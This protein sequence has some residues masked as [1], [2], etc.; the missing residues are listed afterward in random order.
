MLIRFHIQLS[1]YFH[2]QV[3][4]IQDPVERKYYFHAD[5]AIIT[6]THT[7]FTNIFISYIISY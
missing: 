3:C 4:V 7:V 6:D 2:C 5:Y 1:R